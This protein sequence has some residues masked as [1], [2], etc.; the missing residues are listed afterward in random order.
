VR[1]GL[2]DA[3]DDDAA[4]GDA[5]LMAVFRRG[6]PKAV[7]HNSDQGSQGGLNQSSHTFNRGEVYGKASEVDEQVEWSSSDALARCA[8]AS[9][10]NRAAIL[11]TNSNGDYKQKNC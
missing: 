8:I 9:P 4:S 3:T 11:G 2:A 10:E 7:L 6:Q 1:R 5:L